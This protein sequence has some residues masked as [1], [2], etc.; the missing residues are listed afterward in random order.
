LGIAFFREPASVPQL[1]GIVLAL[2]G[3]FLLPS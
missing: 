3:L 1:I 2:T